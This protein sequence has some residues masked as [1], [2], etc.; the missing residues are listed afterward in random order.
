VR[1][2]YAAFTVLAV[3]GLAL[4]GTVAYRAVAASPAASVQDAGG[5]VPV[6]VYTDGSSWFVNVCKP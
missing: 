2:F 6:A 1:R 4:G 3:S 5:L